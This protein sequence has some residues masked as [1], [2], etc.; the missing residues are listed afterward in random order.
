MKN[1]VE[2][3]FIIGDT[4]PWLTISIDQDNLEMMR[5]NV[6][7]SGARKRNKTQWP[8]QDIGYVIST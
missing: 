2:L 6:I 8:L 4:T 5:P 3:T 7:F 1:N